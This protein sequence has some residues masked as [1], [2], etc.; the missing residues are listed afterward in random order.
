MRTRTPMR[1]YSCLVM[2]FAGACGQNGSDAGPG[3]TGGASGSAGAATGGTGGTSGSSGASGFQVPQA[4]ARQGPV[5]PVASLER[6]VLRG[7]L[8][9]PPDRERS[10]RAEGRTACGRGRVDWSGGHRRRRAR[11]SR[12]RASSTS[13]VQRLAPVRAALHPEEDAGKGGT[14]TQMTRSAPVSFTHSPPPSMHRAFEEAV[15]HKAR[16]RPG[17]PTSADAQTCLLQS[18]MSAQGAPSAPG[19]GSEGRHRRSPFS[20]G[21]QPN[22]DGQSASSSQRSTHTP[23]LSPAFTFAHSPRGQL[24][25]DQHHSP[26]LDVASERESISLTKPR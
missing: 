20:R 12:V 24:A 15:L 4:R 21:T 16:H 18:R 11:P 22:W 10:L 1:F 5:V 26:R 19:S 25:S 23:T 8:R 7:P 3:A 14:G 6:R 13:Q 2:L 17:S 9:K